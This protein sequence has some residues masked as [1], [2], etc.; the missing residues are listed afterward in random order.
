MLGVCLIAF[1]IN[2]FKP[3]P[4]T[5]AQLV[6]VA[7]THMNLCSYSPPHGCFPASSLV[8]AGASWKPISSLELGAN[9]STI[10]ADGL[11]EPQPV[12]FFG[13]KDAIT[14]SV[15]F[16]VSTESGHSI[17]LT[18]DH[19]LP[20]ATDNSTLWH[21]RTFKRAQTVAVG[22]Y[23]WV[24]AS[25]GTLRLSKVSSI[26]TFVGQGM[27]NPY[28]LNGATLVDGVAASDHSHWI[29][30]FLIS[31][32]NAN[33]LPALYGPLLQKGL[34]RLY[35]AAPMLVESIN[36]CYYVTAA[37]GTSMEDGICTL[38]KVAI[39]V[40]GATSE[41]LSRALSYTVPHSGL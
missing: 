35:K 23:L 3:K 16:Q 36:K 2:L 9:M 41:F 27:Y 28:S 7:L 5:G 39:W 22:E 13:H 11:I 26:S 21:G 17:S 29:F 30:D 24:S 15:F 34:S 40:K 33:I 19:L 20:I 1:L 14:H 10:R 12:H 6:A 31:D 32:N 38:N 8:H 4:L 18:G 25:N 37:A